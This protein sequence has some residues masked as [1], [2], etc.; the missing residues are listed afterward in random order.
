MLKSSLW[1]YLD[2]YELVKGI[3]TVSDTSATVAI[4]NKANKTV[5]F[6]LCHIYLLHKRSKQCLRSQSTLKNWKL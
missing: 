1:N 3:I 4:A 5:I 6:Q 2:A